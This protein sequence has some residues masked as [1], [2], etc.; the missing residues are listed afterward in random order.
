MSGTENRVGVVLDGFAVPH[1]HT[2]PRTDE[3]P[4][5]FTAWEFVRGALI[6]Y[7]LFLAFT[8]VGWIMFGPLASLVALIYAA[9]VGF[10]TLLLA[11]APLAL[12]AGYLLRRVPAVPV[13]LAWFGA[14]GLVTGMTGVLLFLSVYDARTIWTWPHLPDLSLIAPV[15]WM[16]IFQALL[17]VPS[18]ML[19]WRITSKRA[20]RG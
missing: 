9:P 1:R 8:A 7:G 16:P 19:G 13:H 17:T 3:L 4:M 12:L 14:I 10:A 20:L 15:L 5:A 6:A 18:V 11:G 2:G